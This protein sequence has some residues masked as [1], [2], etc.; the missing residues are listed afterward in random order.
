METQKPFFFKSL[1]Y[2][3]ILFSFCLLAFNVY[4]VWSLIYDASALELG[5]LVV[6][7]TLFL[8]IPINIF[9][10]V[11]V[12][13]LKKNITN[14]FK[15]SGIF[16]KAVGIIL[17]VP[18]FFIF[19]F[20][21]KYGYMFFGGVILMST[22]TK[23]C[24]HLFPESDFDEFSAL[25]GY[26]GS[27]IETYK[28]AIFYCSQFRSYHINNNK[29][30]HS[31]KNLN[32]IEFQ[33]GDEVTGYGSH[34]NGIGSVVLEGQGKKAV[35]ETQYYYYEPKDSEGFKFT[36]GKGPYCNVSKLYYKNGICPSYIYI[37]PGEYK[38]Y[39]EKWWI[40]SNEMDITIK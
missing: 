29:N 3:N 35:V 8:T 6:L 5:A 38:L 24:E 27:N 9:L 37:T 12:F 28:D 23:E 2:F 16:S 17:V 4:C 39:T 26:L 11:S 10:F 25:K 18:V 40:K 22:A 15:D 21:L 19:Y 34:I 31:I 1:Y 7:G 36:L 20:L 33:L 13:T 32:K 30:N 14:T